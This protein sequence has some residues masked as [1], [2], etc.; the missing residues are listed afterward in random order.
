MADNNLTSIT[1][2]SPHVSQSPYVAIIGG[3]LT[4]LA[5]AIALSQRAVPY[6]IYESRGSFTEIGAGIN[7]APNTHEAFNLIDPSLG[8]MVLKIATRN[9]PGMENVWLSVRLGA[10][11]RH[12]E[13]GKLV[14]NIDAPP[15]GNA[16]L[17]RNELLQEMA[18]RIPPENVK[19]NKRVVDLS[20]SETEATMTFSDGSKET[21]GLVIACDGAHSAMR[22]LILGPDN[23][24]AVAHYAE[25]GG[26]RAIFP[27]HKH[28]EAVGAEMAHC[29]HVWSGPNG[30]IIQYPINGGKD[31]NFG[32]WVWKRGEWKDK[33]W[34]LDKQ[35]GKMLEDFRSW[36][37]LVQKMLENMDEETQFWATHHHSVRPKCYF[38]GRAIVIGDAAHSMSPHQGQGAAVSMED[39][40]V[41]AQVVQDIAKHRTEQ[42]KS[43]GQCIEA[44]FTGYEA[45]R[46][47]RF[48]AIFDSSLEA[49][50]FWSDLWREGLTEDDLEKFRKASSERMGWIWNPKLK[51]QGEKARAIARE[52]LGSRT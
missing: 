7:L 9:P 29:S 35:K 47:P 24:A 28:E 26:Y 22:R 14:V 50:S 15:T 23:P 49:M 36:G 30:Y 44:A 31:V 39:S 19:F 3:G 51:E 52:A 34:V 41:M 25:M 16:T 11:T 10:P 21:A 13:D 40:Y 2:G 6:T 32:V 45:V 43:E 38:N 1:M 17:S 46:R 5:L 12:F 33:A 37:P 20:Q 4:G 48:E 27:M 42:G 18:R 8:E